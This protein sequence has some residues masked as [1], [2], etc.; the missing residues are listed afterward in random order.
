[1]HINFI[2]FMKQYPSR[3]KFKKYHK[4]NS[5]FLKLRE[6]KLF[7][8]V[9]GLYGLKALDSC[10]LTFKQIEAGRRTIRRTT[11]KAGKLFINVFTNRSITKKPL[12]S[13]MGKGKGAHHM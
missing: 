11:K 8:P 13:R 10:K 5:S 1:M 7:F 3:L 12:A 6:Q 9:N 2:K 4:S